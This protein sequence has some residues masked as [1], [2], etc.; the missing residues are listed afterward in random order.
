MIRH[1]VRAFEDIRANRFVNA[2]TAITIA[3]VV[4]IVGTALLLVVNTNSVLERW[5]QDTRLMVYLK[6]GAA[7]GAVPRLQQTI[8]ALDGVAACRF[9]PK[10][11]ALQ[12]LRRQLPASSSLLD[13]LE[14]NPLPDAFE[15]GLGTGSAGW[16]R[17][18]AIA[19]RIGAL[20]EV[21]A[22]EYGRKW[23]ELLQ[24][25][26]QLVPAAGAV[27]I[28]LFALSAVAI[29]GG[30]TRLVVYSRRDEV[31]ILRLIGA[32]ERFI[33][34]PFY[35]GGA[36]Q[37]L[38]GGAAGLALLGVVFNTLMDRLGESALPGMLPMRFLRWDEMA[39]VLAGSVL[40]GGLGAWASLRPPLRP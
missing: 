7:A 24:G 21:E 15:V 25:V 16:V 34:A 20:A 39:A 5:Q 1:V 18:G 23:V 33:K 19:A 8:A 13:N 30:T 10:E 28:G 32:A 4:V 3:L 35:L 36:L 40:A 26:L 22:V 14:D 17:V 12:E 29:V 37:G 38:V 31:E 2:V 11:E 6:P 27:V 9:V